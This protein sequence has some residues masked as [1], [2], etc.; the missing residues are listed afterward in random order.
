MTARLGAAA[1]ILVAIRSI[2][3][4][5]AA[6]DVWWH[7]VRIA[8][9][10]RGVLDGVLY[11]R[12]LH[13]VYWGHGGPVML[14]YSPGP[15]V[16]SEIF[17][18]AGAGPMRALELGFAASFVAAAA[19]VYFLS[20]RIFG[21]AGA[22]VAAAAYT[23]AP[24]HLL[25]AWVRGA[26]AEH[27]AM[28]VLPFLLLAAG[29]CIEA[30]GVRGACWLAVAT[31]LVFLTH[32]I[33]AVSFLP[34]AVAYAVWHLLSAPATSRAKAAACVGSGMAGGAILSAFYWIP[35][36]VERPATHILE[37]HASAYRPEPHLLSLRQLF[38]TWWGYGWSGP[39][40][41]TMSFQ[42]G[43]IHLAALGGGAW[44]AHRR[45]D[46]VGRETRFWLAAAG[47]SAL[48][49]TWSSA[50]IWK[51]VPLLPALQYPWRLLSVVAL[52]S[53]LC[54]GALAG[55]AA[56]RGAGSQ[57]AAAVVLIG[58]ALVAYMPFS[59][60]RPPI[61]RDE[62]FVPEALARVM[63]TER[64][65][66]PKGARPD[67]GEGPRLR[68][69]RGEAEV[70]L[71]VDRTHLLEARVRTRDRATLRAR[72]LRFAGWRAQVDG[73]ESPL[74]ADD[75]GA[76]LVDLSEGDH[77]LRLSFGPTPLRTWAGWSSGACL[78]AVA[79]GLLHRPRLPR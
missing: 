29:S 6:H 5:F 25:N 18:L 8:Q 41:D 33:S 75:T 79:W 55:A 46:R 69:V 10:H 17:S 64:M 1:A 73:I 11:P 57:T 67:R 78:A 65:W 71:T 63:A 26:Y 38:E 59:S 52:G 60:I 23:L 21:E 34:L 37:T 19:G 56:A 2:G 68:A 28:A 47:A 39:G 15:Y 35:A 31:A 9:W 14:F 7:L 70:T 32:L 4:G 54:A 36:V 27:L 50:W 74:R 42:I 66:L 77:T 40:P 48:L 72:I 53:S 16:I 45:G 76:I 13:D 20:R 51:V 62:D 44:L 49:T 43:W 3:S 58:A 30:P 22:F 24:Y 61:Y 12:F